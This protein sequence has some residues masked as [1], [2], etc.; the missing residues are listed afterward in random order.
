VEDA[1]ELEA[2]EAVDTCC[3]LDAS[4]L[5]RVMV[6]AEET[7]SKDCRV[8]ILILT[9]GCGRKMGVIADAGNQSD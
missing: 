8:G 5:T 9:G 7:E 6:D 3:G 4:S 1:D 2:M